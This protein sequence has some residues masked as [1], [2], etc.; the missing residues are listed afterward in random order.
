MPEG[1]TE[2]GAALCAALR[3]IDDAWEELKRR[4]F[5]QQKLAL[6][7]SRLPDVSFSEAQ[8]RS[9]V[10]QSLLERL[11][12]FDHGTLPHDIQL[13][14]RLVRFRARIWARE[15]EWYWT[16]IDPRG[17]GMFG[18]F[19]PTAYCGGFMLNYV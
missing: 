15:A 6:I 13:T 12:A 14:L 1:L 7:P 8:R 5:V 3:I 18:L 11:D 2:N 17:V 10:G 4:P 19:L 9:E 16:V